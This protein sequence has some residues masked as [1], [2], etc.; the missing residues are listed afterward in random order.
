[1]KYAAA[2]LVPVLMAGCV[3][4]GPRPEPARLLEAPDLGARAE[5]AALSSTWWRSFKDP[6][7]DALVDAA[8]GNSPSLAAARARVA[9]AN[10]VTE[11]IGRPRRPTIDGNASIA[12][13]RYSGTGLFPPPLGGKT[14]TDAQFGVSLDW[15]LDLWG[16]HRSGRDAAGLRASAAAIDASGARLLVATATVAAYVEFDHAERL[17]E[18]ALASRDSRAALLRLTEERRRAGLDTDVEVE[19]A[20]AAVLSAEGDIAVATER[21][22]LAR[23]A[24]A[25]L[26]GAGPSRGADLAVPHLATSGA[27]LLPEEIPADLLARR[28]DVAADRL[29]IDAATSETEAARAAFYPN[30]NLVGTLGLDTITPAELLNGSSRFFN[31]GPALHLPLFGHSALRGNLHGAEAAYDQ[32]VAAYNGA[33][34]DAIHEVADATASLRALASEEDAAVAAQRSLERAY[35]LAELRYRSGLTNYLGVLIAQDRLLAQ[36]RLVVDVRSRR[37]AL[38]VSLIRALGGGFG[39]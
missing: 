20:R 32:A 14:F 30:V 26:V 27:L 23:N 37:A 35:A 28:P 11:G 33:V 21:V 16:R 10:A 2:L 12:R 7:L 31:V 39:G 38:G 22:E 25:A 3:L 34:V 24:I 19:T 13:E 6:Q 29:R 5:T 4:P 1:M 36:Q 17:L 15:D 8:L 18:T 9:A